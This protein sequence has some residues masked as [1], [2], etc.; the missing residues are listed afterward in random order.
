MNCEL[1]PLWHRGVEVIATVQLQA[2]KTELRF[3]AGSNPA[4]CES[5]IRV[6]EDIRQWPRLEIGLHAFSRSTIPQK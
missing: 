4:R 3:C 5:E 1:K 6:G 2:A